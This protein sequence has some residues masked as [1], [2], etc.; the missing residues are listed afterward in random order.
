MDPVL[1]SHAYKRGR[2]TRAD[3]RCNKIQ[4]SQASYEDRKSRSQQGKY[5]GHRMTSQGEKEI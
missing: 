4:E 1:A 3:F 2:S 5:Q